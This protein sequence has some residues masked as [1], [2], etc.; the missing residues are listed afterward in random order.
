MASELRGFVFAVSFIVFFSAFL[1]TIPADFQGIEQEFDSIT[2]IDPVLLS[3]F[4]DYANYS[5]S[6][7]VGWPIPDYEYDSMGGY[8]WQ[9]IY[10]SDNHF[11]LARKVLWF[12]LWLGA[13]LFAD[14][15]NEEGINN[16]QSLS[17][18]EIEADAID[19]THR[20]NL[21]LE[22]GDSAGGFVVFWNITEYPDP[23]D[24]WDNDEFYIVHGLGIGDSATTNIGN[25]IIGLLF[26]QIPDVPALVN[27]FIVV[28]I[29]ANVI[30]VLWFLIKEMIPFV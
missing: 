10:A 29:W 24:A 20:Y 5:E 28:P 11:F 8:N 7:F 15:I 1:T 23:N 25:L 3:G 12:G 2:P 30:Y 18:A 9:A 16:G 21:E 13:K 6:A 14:F 4:D 19:G 17:W 27:I 26:L 22:N